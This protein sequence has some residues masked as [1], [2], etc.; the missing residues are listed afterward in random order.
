M[1]V[2]EKIMK[3]PHYSKLMSV[4]AGVLQTLSN[5][6]SLKE[7]LGEKDADTFSDIAYTLSDTYS[8]YESNAKEGIAL[9]KSLK[10]FLRKKDANGRKY[11][12]ALKTAAVESGIPMKTF[13]ES[14]Y[15]L[16]DKLEVGLDLPSLDRESVP[17]KT[18]IQGERSWENYCK[19]HL[20]GLPYTQK[21]K[22]DY[23]AKALTGAFF[24][25]E[26]SRNPNA[27]ETPFSTSAARKYTEQIK[28]MP[29]FKQLC[30]DPQ[31]IDRLL[32]EGAEDPAKLF[33]TAVRMH[34]PFYQIPKEK[35]A[36]VLEKLKAMQ[37]LMDGPDEHDEKWKALQ[38]SISEIDL[39]DPQKSGTL[40]LKEIFNNTC[41]YMKGKKSLRKTEEGRRCFDQSMDILA[42]LALCGEHAEAAAQSVIDRTNEVRLGHNKNYDEIS[43]KDFGANKILNHMN[44]QDE[45]LAQEYRDTLIARN[46][47]PAEKKRNIKVFEDLPELDFT[48]L[49]PLPKGKLNSAMKV[50][51]AVVEC[52]PFA[53][54]APLSFNDAKDQVAMILALSECQM[55]FKKSRENGKSAVMFDSMEYM[56]KFNNYMQDKTVHE[57]AKK[58]MSPEGR[59]PYINGIGKEDALDAKKL[60]EDYAQVKK[61]MEG[62]AVQM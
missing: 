12:D 9:A 11:Y 22:A 55:F 23:L 5:T 42:E 10:S 24:A 14:L 18:R 62:P 58:C 30:K 8:H 46:G 61:E 19:A 44:R 40:K 31:A 1:G 32:K 56:P 16:D 38:D 43:L 3:D 27:A 57:L 49:E 36:E 51:D 25:G 35:A 60:R 21:G 53:S 33:D 20:T 6:A 26:R 39:E 13:Y 34:E 15:Y 54:D 52:R 29:V 37:P 50:K 59:R 17:P 45:E 28:K 41:A 48:L 2:Y 47:L 7:S 4:A